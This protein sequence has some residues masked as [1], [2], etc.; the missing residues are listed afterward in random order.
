VGD[1]LGARSFEEAIREGTE[2]ALGAVP[3]PAAVH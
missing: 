1:A 2:A 3:A